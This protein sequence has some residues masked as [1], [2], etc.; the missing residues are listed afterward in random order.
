MSTLIPLLI[1]TELGDSIY[2]S[3]HSIQ[4]YACGMSLTL[5]HDQE[6]KPVKFKSKT[7]NKMI[8]MLE[9][10]NFQIHM[11]ED[12]FERVTAALDFFAKETGD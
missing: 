9:H 11:N 5:S 6:L 10:G 1:K 2:I 3:A 7:E 4:F 12:E 8:Y